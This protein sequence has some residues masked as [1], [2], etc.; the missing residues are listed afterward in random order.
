MAGWSSVILICGLGDEKLSPGVD[1][2]GLISPSVVWS[3][4]GFDLTW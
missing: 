1:V 4:G 2:V 3:Y